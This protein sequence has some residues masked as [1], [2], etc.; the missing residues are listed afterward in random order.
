MNGQVYTSAP[1]RKSSSNLSF[2]IVPIQ[3]VVVELL[4]LLLLDEDVDNDEA[5]VMMV[6]DWIVLVLV[7]EALAMALAALINQLPHQGLDIVDVIIAASVYYTYYHDFHNNCSAISDSTMFLE[8]LRRMIHVI[9]THVLRNVSW[10]NT[11]IES[12]TDGLPWPVDHTSLLLYC[13]LE[14]VLQYGTYCCCDNSTSTDV[15]VDDTNVEDGVMVVVV[16]ALYFRNNTDT[17]HWMV[18]SEDM[19][20]DIALHIQ[21]GDSSASFLVEV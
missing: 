15:Y 7:V 18:L 19:G 13:D 4:L 20:G 3:L 10:H 14:V 21:V 1:S 16:V 2:E 5:V 9:N 12:Y 11:C 6:V 8:A 17:I